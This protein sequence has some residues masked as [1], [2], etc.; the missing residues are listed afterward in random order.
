MDQGKVT[1]KY[2][3]S[4]WSADARAWAWKIIAVDLGKVAVGLRKVTV[5]QVKFALGLEKVDVDLRKVA[6]DLK[7]VDVGLI[8][9][10]VD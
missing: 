8:H 9:V 1:V 5:Y 7:K 10:A 6:V 4:S 2:E 3:K